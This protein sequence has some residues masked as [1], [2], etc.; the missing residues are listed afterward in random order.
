MGIQPID[1]R[2]FAEKAGFARH[3]N[4]RPATSRIETRRIRLVT[5]HDLTGRAGGCC[6]DISPLPFVF[7]IHFSTFKELTQMTQ[8]V[9]DVFAGD[10]QHERITMES[11][12]SG[13]VV[14]DGPNWLGSGIITDGTYYGKVYYKGDHG[15]NAKPGAMVFHRMTWN[16]AGWF[17]GVAVFLS[18]LV[19]LRWME[20]TE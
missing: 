16:P 1:V 11:F 12:A 4:K 8:R 18:G 7:R 13:V 15:P 19:D 5:R 6:R 20:V 2:S 14:V 3:H 17:E 9:F 10:T